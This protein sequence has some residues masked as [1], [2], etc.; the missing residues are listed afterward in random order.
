[1]ALELYR[2]MKAWASNRTGRALRGLVSGGEAKGPR[3][4][5][6]MRRLYYYIQYEFLMAVF[7]NF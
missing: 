5:E 4:N 1:V 6:K 2:G 7:E 3:G